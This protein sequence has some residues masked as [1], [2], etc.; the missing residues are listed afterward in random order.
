MSL[1]KAIHYF[2]A[3]IFGIT[4]PLYATFVP[5]PG[6]TLWSLV[7][8]V[9]HEV[10]APVSLTEIISSLN[11]IYG[12]KI[13][14]I[15]SISDEIQLDVDGF[16]S[17]IESLQESLISQIDV[18]QSDIGI[19]ASALD[20]VDLHILSVSD[21]ISAAISAS[22]TLLFSLG[23]VIISVVENV[24]S[25]LESTLDAF[26]ACI[27][28]TMLTQADFNGGTL[29]ITD[30]GLYTLCEDITFSGAVAV[31]IQSDNVVLDLNNHSISTDNNN[32]INIIAVSEVVVKNGTL[33][34]SST[35]VVFISN[36][37]AITIEAI[38]GVN[39]GL[40]I[41]NSQDIF[42][43]N[44][45]NSG[46]SIGVLASNVDNLTVRDAVLEN[47]T[48]FGI[49]VTLSRFLIERCRVDSAATAGI[50][51]QSTFDGVVRDCYVTNTIDGYIAETIAVG[52]CIEFDHVIAEN[53]VR[54]FAN[55]NSNNVLVVESS[56]TACSFGIEIDGGTDMVIKRCSVVNNGFG[57]SIDAASV[58]TQ[59][60]DSCV[61]NNST[62]IINAGTNTMVMD[63]GTFF[64]I[65]SSK[66]ENLDA[67][68]ISDLEA[69]ASLLDSI[70]DIAFSE[71]DAVNDTA[72]CLVQT[73]IKQS[74]LPLLI[75]ASGEYVVCEPLVHN[76]SPAITIN[77]D[78]VVL[79]LNQYTL[80]TNNR[81][82][83][84]T[85][86]N[87]ITIRNGAIRSGREA[88]V[89]S[90]ATT[91]AIADLEIY[92]P[93]DI[94]VHCTTVNG[95]HMSGST[96]HGNNGFVTGAATPGAFY[97]DTVDNGTVINSHVMSAI[98][99]P[100]RG[101]VCISTPTVSVIVI[102]NSTVHNVM[103]DGFL[104]VE[105][106]SANSSGIIFDACCAIQATNGF[107][108]TNSVVDL[109]PTFRDCVALSCTK[110]FVIQ[111]ATG[112]LL[113]GCIAMQSSS[114]GFSCDVTSTGLEFIACISN[115]NLIGFD[116]PG[117]NNTGSGCT[118]IG[119]T[120]QGVRL[121]A[122]SGDTVIH[123]ML[124]GRNG[125]AGLVDG[126]ATTPKVVDVRSQ[127]PANAVTPNP[128]YILNGA[129]DSKGSSIVIRTS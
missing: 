104:V 112:T 67:V 92:E 22:E 113:E 39:T 88:V 10:N 40:N 96:V 12:S 93:A 71:L 94:A 99:I 64:E 103:Q 116:L 65:L 101:F 127:D 23:D 35:N 55:F 86:H 74:D 63:L 45:T 105:A 42:V 129:V 9:G 128:A 118:A 30:P 46:T 44:Y 79:N 52:N 33:I 123:G 85:G 115:Y 126:G 84:S 6:E 81:A 29:F 83:V 58:N 87:N 114:S 62:N 19:W 20:A 95:L 11:D 90:S 111:A 121:S 1:K 97:L 77:A 109:G 78:N 13:E 2:Y 122:T 102:E 100:V 47:N 110:G 56:F 26:A 54:G 120:F 27:H 107:S 41:A 14:I 4:L 108:T 7:D 49:Y 21:V 98:G 18:I 37:S 51:A 17:R 24:E 16:E 36:A 34:S 3:A 15:G 125:S 50:F 60:L 76:G 73:A 61:V 25:T 124:L 31:A 119:N 80:T 32:V 70:F 72:H 38:T 43:H 82:V 89:I 69:S 5:L 91:V 53:C 66:L 59:I 57:I 68:I 28:G 8:Q 117:A 75:S 106:G 48:L